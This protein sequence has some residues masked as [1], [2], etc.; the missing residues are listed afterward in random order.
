MDKFSY[1]GK[2]RGHNFYT[3]EHACG[4][5][6]IHSF[7]GKIDPNRDCAYRALKPCPA[8]QAASGPSKADWQVFPP[9]N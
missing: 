8:C 7:K 9:A 5:K 6:L 2:R 3:I 4:H 1:Y